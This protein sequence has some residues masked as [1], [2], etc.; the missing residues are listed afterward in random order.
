MLTI[1]DPALSLQVF[2]NLTKVNKIMIY[3]KVTNNKL[4]KR[5]WTLFDLLLICFLYSFY[6]TEIEVCEINMYS[7]PQHSK[8]P[9]CIRIRKCNRTYFASIDDNFAVF[10]ACSKYN[11]TLIR[12]KFKDMGE[13]KKTLWL[14]KGLIYKLNTTIP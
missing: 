1:I 8:L 13:V 4:G 6:P 10:I 14:L 12:N 5:G 9:C 2:E 3:G 7:H 11:T